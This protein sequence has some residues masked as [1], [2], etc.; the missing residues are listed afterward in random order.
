M[1]GPEVPVLKWLLVVC[2]AA[3]GVTLSAVCTTHLPRSIKD[4][5][6]FVHEHLRG[7][8]VSAAL[9]AT[10]MLTPWSC[11]H[12][13]LLPG[14][15]LDGCSS[16]GLPRHQHPGSRPVRVLLA[17]PVVPVATLEP[18]LFPLP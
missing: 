17:T 14:N 11:G 5:Q 18:A 8:R 15:W 10:V 3:A 1:N 16:P 9:N 7:F 6:G 2:A 12:S 13:Y 4:S